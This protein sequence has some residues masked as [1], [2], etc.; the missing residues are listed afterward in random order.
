MAV[1]APP[2][3][4]L[5]ISLRPHL[6]PGDTNISYELILQKFRDIEKPIDKYLTLRDL[7]RLAPKVSVAPSM[8][9]A[10]WD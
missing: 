4:P 2:L 3:P 10:C 5:S 9:H 1:P 6:L 8:P 7:L